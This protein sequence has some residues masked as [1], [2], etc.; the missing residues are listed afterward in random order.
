MAMVLSNFGQPTIILPMNGRAV[1]P[2]VS[3]FPLPTS[4][5]TACLQTSFRLDLV[6]DKYG[7]ETEWTVKG[8]AGGM[9]HT[10]RSYSGNTVYSI[11]ECIPVDACVF[12]ITDSWGDSIRCEYGTGSYT[13][14][15]NDV[16]V[17]SGGEFGSSENVDLCGTTQPPTTVSPTTSSIT[18][19][20]ADYHISHY[21]GTNH[22]V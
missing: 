21:F 16:E 5:P 19:I 9:V 11:E 7:S 15:M 14:F 18:H 17:V 12:T 2:R 10:G 3:S 1:V 13:V 20:G 8:N 22:N 6:T 4:A